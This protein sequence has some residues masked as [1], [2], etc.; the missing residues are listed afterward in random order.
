MEDTLPHNRSATAIGV[1]ST[2]PEQRFDVLR[3]GVVL[4]DG[5]LAGRLGDLPIVE[6]VYFLHAD[7]CTG[8]VCVRD[9]L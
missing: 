1:K 8:S 2:R 6:N 4:Q 3:G 7:L 5:S 9:P